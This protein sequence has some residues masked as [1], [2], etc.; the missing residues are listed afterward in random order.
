[1][2]FIMYTSNIY[3]RRIDL[4][5]YVDIQMENDA[6]TETKIIGGETYG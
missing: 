5:E 6:G 3:C 2:A 4:W 1:M